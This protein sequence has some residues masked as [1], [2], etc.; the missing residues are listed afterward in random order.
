MNETIPVCLRGDLYNDSCSPSLQDVHFPHT[1]AADGNWKVL[2]LDLENVPKLFVK[3]HLDSTGY[4][5][6]TTDLSRLWEERLSKTECIQRASDSG[7][8]IDPSQDDEQFSILLGKIETAFN[9]E[10]DTSLQLRT[11]DEDDGNLA[12]EISAALPKP[13]S[14]FKWTI[15]LRLQ[16]P[17]YLA[18]QLVTPLL[19]QASQLQYQIDQLVHELQNKDRVI[20]KICDRLETSGN[21]LTT[22]FPGVSN[23]KTSRKKGQREQLARHVKGLADFDEDAWKAQSYQGLD[24]DELTDGELNS[25]LGNLPKVEAQ[26]SG[27]DRDG[28]WNHLDPG[29]AVPRRKRPVATSPAQHDVAMVEDEDIQDSMFQRQATPPGLKQQHATSQQGHESDHVVE[30]REGRASDA[31]L[32]NV[33][34]D[35]QSTTEDE[36]D[37]DAAPK[38]AVPTRTRRSIT[39]QRHSAQPSPKLPNRKLGNIG[40]QKRQESALVQP[41]PRKL[42]TVGG[43]SSQ[44]VLPSSSK[45]STPA[46]ISPE[47]K[48]RAK[49]GA[50]G[51]R[52]KKTLPAVT[53]SEPSEQGSPPPTKGHKMGT[54]GGKR[55]KEGSID[56]TVAEGPTRSE[57]DEDELPSRARALTKE[58]TPPPRETS[59]ER[60]NRKRDQ[61]KRDLEEKAKAPVKKK[62][63]F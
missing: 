46:I 9:H 22:V 3:C 47:S 61:L 21:D 40:G 63:R 15:E 56:G 55:S 27:G 50:I 31:I 51:G 14:A 38:Q 4:S 44:S 8:S 54:I 35:G 53:E 45:E 41:S 7:S 26:D 36:D 28:G 13:L 20:S 57:N 37:L 23:I 19:H 49:L 52:A 42:G 17:Q 62:R 24:H 60:A 18:T 25:V 59:Q 2:D 39:P 5:I 16:E 10:H 32:P 30:T 11:S 12:I 34:D 6:Q 43:R 1:M 48:P 33:A 58:A 29:A